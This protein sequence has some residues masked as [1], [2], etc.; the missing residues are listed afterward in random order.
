MPEASQTPHP[1]DLQ[2]DLTL[3]IEMAQD[4][5]H[6]EQAVIRHLESLKTKLERFVHHSRA[7]SGEGSAP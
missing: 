7:R 2:S 6:D 3:L 4:A 5:K 1:D